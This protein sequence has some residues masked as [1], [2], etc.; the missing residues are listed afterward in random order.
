M[1]NLI[2]MIVT[3]LLSGLI[4]VIVTLAVQKRTAKRMEKM[5]IFKML[6]SARGEGEISLELIQNLNIIDV[7]FYHKEY[8]ISAWKSLHQSYIDN[9]FNAKE[10]QGKTMELLQEMAKHLGYENLNWD[11]IN[12]SYLSFGMIDILQKQPVHGASTPVE[13]K[14]DSSKY[15]KL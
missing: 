6:M 9:G 3:A 5:A 1:D 4:G 10:T 8:V 15:P 14:F 2:L 13:T 12:N 11:T 7:V